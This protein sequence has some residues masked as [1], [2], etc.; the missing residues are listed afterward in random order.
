MIPK[1]LRC[2]TVFIVIAGVAASPGCGK[3]KQKMKMPDIKMIT[4]EFIISGAAPDERNAW[5]VADFGVIYH[6]SDGGETWQEQK[7]GVDTLLTDAAFVDG[8]NGWVTGI[9]GTILHTT[10]G[11][12]TWARQNAGTERHLLAVSFADKDYGWAVGEFSIV[13]HTSDGGATWQQQGEEQDKI[14][15]DV[16]F[17]DRSSGWI[18]G[19]DGVIVHTLN[20]GATWEPVVPDFFK[21]ATIEEEYDNPRPTLFGISFTD[22]DHGWLCG[23]DSTI[24]HTSDGGASWQAVNKGVDILLNIAVKGERGWAV[25]PQGVYLLSRDKGLTWEIQKD[26]VKSKLDFA[27]VIFSSPQKGFIVG[28]SGTL[29]ATADGGETWKFRSGMSYEFEGFQMPA[30]LEKRIIE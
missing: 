9:K 26:A 30:A 7:S 19:E 2:A 8:Q 6:S 16:C 5:I 20:S 21:R 3:A 15:N 18:V 27:N 10:D 12:A 1:L 24:L 14:Y 13:L 22:K 25:G 17:I 4:S 11:G 28:A 29:V 23:M